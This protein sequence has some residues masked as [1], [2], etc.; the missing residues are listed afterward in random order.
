MVS[1]I[2]GALQPSE[3]GQA[4]VPTSPGQK[5]SSN[6]EARPSSSL[7]WTELDNRFRRDLPDEVYV[8]RMGF[9]GLVMRAC[10]RMV[11]LDGVPVTDAEREK[12]G[13]LLKGLERSVNGRSK[14]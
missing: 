2:S 7:P 14:A 5:R 1:D 8:A 3:R 6:G 13:K 4:V 12:T 10:P 11:N 9:R